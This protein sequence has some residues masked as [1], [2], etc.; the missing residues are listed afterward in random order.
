MDFRLLNFISHPLRFFLLLSV[1]F[2]P[3]SLRARDQPLGA[4]GQG[5]ALHSYE[6]AQTLIQEEKFSEAEAVLL[7]LLESHPE[8]TDWKNTLCAL[9]R[10]QQ[11]WEASEACYREVLARDAKN[12][13]ALNGLGHLERSQGN[14]QVSRQRF[15]EVLQVDPDNYEALQGLNQ[16]EFLPDEAPTRFRVDV[17]G[18]AEAYNFFSD[19]TGA[20]FQIIYKQPKKYF[21]LGRFDYLD[22][23]DD[24]SYSS[25]LGGGYFVH[26]RILLSDQIAFAPTAVVVPQFSNLFEIS[27]EAPHGLNPY[28]RYNYRHYSVANVHMLTPG[29]SWYFNS[30]GVWDVNYT[31]TA[32]TLEGVSGIPVNNSFSTRLTFIPLEDRFTLYVWYA[33]NEESFDAGN[34]VNPL[35]SFTAQVVG[36]G[37]E[38]VMV[39][40]IG[41]KFDPSY[42]NRNNGQTV[43]TYLAGLFYRW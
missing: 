29:M 11:K 25:T 40:N 1:F 9:Y 30:W 36:G 10:W 32:Q 41:L 16:L 14:K 3:L 20:Y 7:P 42:E 23:F 22:K 13:D 37:F 31:M 18:L 34:P 39:K 2:F 28:L 26:P 12:T 6:Q 4:Y 33:R 24:K 38:W 8:N 43:H 15:Q 21:V 17:G 27:G 19:A 35:G 5:G